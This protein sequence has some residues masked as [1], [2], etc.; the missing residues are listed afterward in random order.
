MNSSRTIMIVDDDRGFAHS[1]AGLLCTAGYRTCVSQDP[2]GAMLHARAQPVDCALVDY[3]LGATLGTALI[4]R[5]GD[6]GHAFPKIMITGFGDVRTATQAMKLGASD[7]LEKPCDPEE[8]LTTIETA[9]ARSRERVQLSDGIREARRLLQQLT[10]RESEIVDAI[11]AGRSSRQIA[12]ALSV[13]QRTVE[14]HR[15][16]VLQKLGISNTASLVRLAVLAGL[17]P[18]QG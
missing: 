9:M 1:L 14:A 4:A 15:A 12:D 17:G 8:L 7:F 18:P 5:L 11:V 2:A 6:E 10:A 16:N 13:S 3:N